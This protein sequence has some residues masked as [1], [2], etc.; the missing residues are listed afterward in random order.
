MDNMQLQLIYSMDNIQQNT[1][2]A[3][4]GVCESSFSYKGKEKD[5]KGSNILRAKTVKNVFELRFWL[6]EGK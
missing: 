5:I 1:D 6:L 3:L 4:W 2:I